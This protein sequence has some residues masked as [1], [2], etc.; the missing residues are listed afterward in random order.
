MWP[1]NVSVSVKLLVTCERWTRLV[2]RDLGDGSTRWDVALRAMGHFPLIHEDAVL[3]VV[4]R[5][6]RCHGLADGEHRWSVEVGPLP[7][8]P[9]VHA[10]S[11]LVPGSRVNQSRSLVAVDLATGERAHLPA[12]AASADAAARARPG[13]HTRGPVPV[14]AGSLVGTREG[15]VTHLDPHEN[16]LGRIHLGW[17]RL[18]GLVAVPASPEHLRSGPLAVALTQ[19]GAVALNLTADPSTSK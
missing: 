7:G 10:G 6:L 9:R 16:V 5:E 14:V 1:Q 12:A 17:P 2:A 8:H 11:V 18:Q 3:L 19:S 4:D 15:V 13:R